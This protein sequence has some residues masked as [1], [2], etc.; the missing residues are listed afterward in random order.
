MQESYCAPGWFGI[1][2]PINEHTSFVGAK[3]DSGFDLLLC[4]QVVREICL[5]QSQS[6]F[7]G[8]IEL[9]DVLDCA[10]IPNIKS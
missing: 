9:R 1:F 6:A 2:G 10:T 4:P 3:S 8:Q 5:A 7:Q